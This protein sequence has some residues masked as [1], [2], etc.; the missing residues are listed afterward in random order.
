MLACLVKILLGLM[1]PK[2]GKECMKQDMVLRSR[3]LPR[4]RR[5]V[6]EKF[7]MEKS[8][9]VFEKG[10]KTKNVQQLHELQREYLGCQK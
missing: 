4:I 7:G 1:T 8:K 9:V 2:Y 10:I 6:L 3:I 5:K